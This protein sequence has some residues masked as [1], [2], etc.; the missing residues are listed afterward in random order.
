MLAFAVHSRIALTIR[1]DFANYYE[2]RLCM[3]VARRPGQWVAPI[4][5]DSC[6]MA[7]EKER[8]NR[9]RRGEGKTRVTRSTLSWKT[10]LSELTAVTEEIKKRGKLTE[11]DLSLE[12]F[13]EALRRNIRADA[14]L[15]ASYK[16]ILIAV[17][18][19]ECAQPHSAM[20]NA[21]V[22]KIH[23][24][25]HR[26]RWIE[27]H[28]LFGPSKRHGLVVEFIPWEGG[29]HLRTVEA[30]QGAS[31]TGV[32]HL[33]P[34][35][36]NAYAFIRTHVDRQKAVSSAVFLEFSSANARATI[37]H[38]VW[39]AGD[40]KR[41]ELFVHEP[42]RDTLN[43]AQATR[44]VN[45]LQTLVMVL[46]KNKRNGRPQG[47]DPAPVEKALV[48]ISFYKS[49]ASVKGTQVYC[50]VPAL[51]VGWYRYTLDGDNPEVLDIDADKVPGVVAIQSAH[52]AE[53]ETYLDL[54]SRIA[55]EYRRR[56][57]RAPIEFTVPIGEAEYS[58]LLRKLAD[59]NLE[60][61]G[62]ATDPR[63]LSLSLPE[64]PDAK[65][66][67]P[68]DE[69]QQR[70]IQAIRDTPED[71][72]QTLYL[73][74]LHGMNIYSR[75]LSKL[76][77]GDG[78]RIDRVV[79]RTIAAD[80]EPLLIELGLVTSGYRNQLE[81]N[82]DAM[83]RL[84]FATNKNPATFITEVPWGRHL[85]PILGCLFGD[86][87]EGEYCQ[88]WKDGRLSGHGAPTYLYTSQH[89]YFAELKALFMGSA[90]VVPSGRRAL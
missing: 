11:Y 81:Q 13:V 15:G 63:P 85:P 60:V 7:I 36:F 75:L 27:S 86:V 9:S 22:G 46:K 72:P 73:S 5:K 41:V 77:S 82:L 26:A 69:A 88:I 48:T 58:R 83:R 47:G 2:Q 49:P 90:A 65:W 25:K 6:R 66:E 37:E 23:F 43:P 17:N 84:P 12:R 64:R 34:E 24:Y 53:Y 61:Q 32:P 76:D 18:E 79:V 89:P 54:M 4:K 35:Q 39:A 59:L 16:P 52:P 45:S 33:F 10:L 40:A 87:L 8:V 42:T 51:A 80:V 56:P 38:V 67:V 57:A 44:I 20:W 68:M 19:V 14:A 50:D 55:E 71:H 28:R 62:A 74:P 21:D 3:L 30:P 1:V 70:I 31:D 29:F 78:R